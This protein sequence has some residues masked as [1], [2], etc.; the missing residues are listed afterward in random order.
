MIASALAR[1]EHAELVA[2]RIGKDDPA[3]LAR[4]PPVK[5]VRPAACLSGDVLAVDDD[6]VPTQ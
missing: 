6:G 3:D 4:D 5:D 1:G 2:L